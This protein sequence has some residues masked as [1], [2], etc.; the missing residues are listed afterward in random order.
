LSH[1]HW[2]RG[3]PGGKEFGGQRPR[4]RGN[5]LEFIYRPQI[6]GVERDCRCAAQDGIRYTER[7]TR[8]GLP[9]QLQR[10]DKVVSP[11]SVIV[12]HLESLHMERIARE[13]LICKRQQKSSHLAIR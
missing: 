9:E 3:K 4:V 8:C 12:Q 10:T 5:H 13:S 11:K 1:H 2:H 7:Q 6:A